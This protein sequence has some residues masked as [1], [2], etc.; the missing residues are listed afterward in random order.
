MSRKEEVIGII[1]GI[2]YSMIIAL[3]GYL[4]WTQYKP[5]SAL[6]WSF[7]FGIAVSNLIQI[8]DNVREGLKFA[9]SPLLKFTIALLGLITSIT[10]WFQVGIGVI[11]ALVIIV[12]SFFSSLFLGRKIGISNRLAILIGVGTSICGASA[13]AAVAS[14]INAKEEEIGL[15]ISGITLF[16]LI[17]MFL[18][19]YLFSNTFVRQLL[20]EKSTVYAIWV[21]SG[22][23]ESAQVIAAARTVCIECV[24][25][26]LIV[27]SIRIFMIGPIVM[28]ST[29]F[30]NRFETPEKQL[31]TKFVVPLFAVLFVINSVISAGLDSYST[32]I[33]ILGPAW[34]FTKRSLKSSLIPFL[35]A[36]SFAGVGSKVK[37]RDIAK[38]GW[39][40]FGFAAIMSVIAGVLALIMAAVI[41]RYVV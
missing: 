20:L 22:V 24:Q 18:Y 23:H 41:A 28:T 26:A 10:I 4:V 3:I 21:G 38:V 8:P 11:N 15:A 31:K 9:S 30:L 35:L 17:S 7:I 2:I 32:M 33:P 34:D 16:G 14:A 37:F 40:P 1:P 36:I 13:I 25:P 6:M 29:Y 27:K 12:F 39:N 19:P 5:V